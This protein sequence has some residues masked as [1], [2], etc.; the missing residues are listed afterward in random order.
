[1]HAVLQLGIQDEID[2]ALA[3]DTGFTGE[4]GCDDTHIKMAFTMTVAGMTH[5]AGMAGGIVLHLDQG[6]MKGGGEL[7]A[8]QICTFHGT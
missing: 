4:R 3:F 7:V 1:M 2:Q 5:M 6:G 8:D